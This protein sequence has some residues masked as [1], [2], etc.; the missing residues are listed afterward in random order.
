MIYLAFTFLLLSIHPYVTYPLFLI[1]ASKVYWSN[2]QGPAQLAGNMTKDRSA[3]NQELAR[4]ALF[5]C[6]RNEE[7]VIEQ[8]L[9]NVLAL[10][11][12]NF[13]LDIYVFDDASS[14][15][16]RSLLMKY[17][18]EIN[19]VCSDTNIGKSSGMNAL[20]KACDSDYDY[21]VFTDANTMLDKKSVA[22][23]VEHFSSVSNL[24]LVAGVSVSTNTDSSDVAQMST[25]YWNF[26]VWL[27]R[28]ESQICGIQGA[29]GAF[30]SIPF[31][32][33]TPVPH[34]IIDDFYT[35]MTVNI[36][37][38]RTI[39]AD[40]CLVYEKNVTEFWGEFRRKRRIACRAHNCTRLL[41]PGLRKMSALSQFCFFSRKVLRWYGFTFF[42]ATITGFII[43]KGSTVSGLI[44]DLRNSHDVQFLV[45]LGFLAF[46][47][48]FSFILKIGKI[49]GFLIAVNL[50][51]IDSWR[52]KRYAVW[53]PDQTAR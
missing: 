22:N 16:T 44:A 13:N 25:G 15:N 42:L 24:G 38:L 28:L 11:K 1:M 40:D 33:Y 19:I 17:S 29:D 5:F 6:A 39:Q 3:K 32:L 23:V 35:S 21:I 53:N 27:K 8:K 9:D 4:V 34:D 12:T 20:H 45:L 41:W 36:S 52:G 14:D 47:L 26:D 31:D 18:K 37:G 2:S 7:A 30:F 50:G 48:S 10:D 43:A 49:I 51:V 46:L